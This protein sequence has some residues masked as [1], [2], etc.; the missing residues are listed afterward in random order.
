MARSTTGVQPEVV[1]RRRLRMRC[2]QVPVSLP[3]L[4][5]LAIAKRTPGAA[6]GVGVPSLRAQIE[7]HRR[8]KAGHRRI[9]IPDDDEARALGVCQ[10]VPSAHCATMAA[11]S[12]RMTCCL[13]P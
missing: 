11:T 13:V 7:A 6:N 2:R 9:L 8:P 4:S 5:S 12:V 1:N 3:S 10:A